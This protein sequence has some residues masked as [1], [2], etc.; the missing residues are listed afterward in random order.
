MAHACEA[1]VLGQK[2]VPWPD[3]GHIEPARK[4]IQSRGDH[5][6]RLLLFDAIQL[7]KASQQGANA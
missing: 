7:V 2:F 6:P 3:W 1:T 5:G 4:L